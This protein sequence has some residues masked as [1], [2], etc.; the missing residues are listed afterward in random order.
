MDGGVCHGACAA[1][2]ALAFAAAVAPRPL[3]R[4]AREAQFG[5]GKAHWRRLCALR[6]KMTA[7][8]AKDAVAPPPQVFFA[9]CPKG[10]GS[11]LAREIE[12]PEIAGTVERTLFSGVEFVGQSM[13]TGY[14]ACLW[15]RTGIRVLHL[16][17]RSSD[18]YEANRDAS[19]YDALYAFVRGAADWGA[20]LAGD[21]S[22]FSVQVREP[23]P[24]SQRPVRRD[25]DDGRGRGRRAQRGGRGRRRQATDREAFGSQ[26]AQICAKDA[27]CDALRD[28]GLAVPE[29][30]ASHASSDVP[31]FLALHGPEASL[32]RDMA[33]TSLHK[34]CAQVP[35]PVYSPAQSGR[36][37]FAL[38]PRVERGLSPPRCA[39]LSN[40]G[41]RS[42]SVLHRSSLNEAV[43]AGMLMLSGFA[44]DGSFQSGRREAIARQRGGSVAGEGGEA[45]AGQGAASKP[46]RL[47]LC[48]PMCGSATLL[49]EAA[50]FRLHVAPGLYRREF[51]FERWNGFDRAG[52]AAIVDDAVASQRADGDM[53]MVL[54]GNDS[55]PAALA[56]ARRDL[57]RTN[58]SH[59]VRLVEGNAEVL[60]L[61][62]DATIVACNPPWGLRIGG[63]VEAW[64]ALG[65]FLRRCAGGGTAILLSGDA[66]LTQSLRMRAREKHPIRCVARVR[67]ASGATGTHRRQVAC[68]FAPLTV[69]FPFLFPRPPAASG[70]STA[71]RS[72]TTFFRQ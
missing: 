30:P 35:L 11:V 61:E 14:A 57:E 67:P 55:N 56:L 51:P 25:E 26:R 42:D 12:S 44:P 53:N 24:V 7:G 16:L 66:G 31:L 72:C 54:I 64:E 32:Y 46:R 71:A 39:S 22:T 17:G 4:R 29:R 41:Y 20:L 3:V 47:V 8:T 70:M 63:E 15:L 6:P 59:L 2:P 58:L 23:P 21:A 43:A 28:A 65:Q 52:Y 9:T 27:I 36:L 18:M 37:H 45:T 69:A 5:G 40:R 34:R 49:I 19:D 50:L 1:S 68:P 48:D 13:L 60:T 62:E 10:L 33:G 38:T